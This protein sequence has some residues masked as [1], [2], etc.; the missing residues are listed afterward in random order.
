MEDWII[1]RT[2][3]TSVKT[4]TKASTFVGIAVP[5]SSGTRVGHIVAQ[6]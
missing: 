3:E 1:K 4:I 2:S 6:G 5:K